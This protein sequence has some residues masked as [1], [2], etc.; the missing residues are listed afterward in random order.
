VSAQDVTVWNTDVRN[1]PELEV[2]IQIVTAPHEV[3]GEFYARSSPALEVEML[4][5]AADEVPPPPP[6][7]FDASDLAMWSFDGLAD[8]TDLTDELLEELNELDD[9]DVIYDAPPPG[10]RQA[11][12]AQA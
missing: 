8:L 1:R 10:Y 7:L 11:M 2:E 4:R 12:Q 6:R 5:V 3:P 9:L